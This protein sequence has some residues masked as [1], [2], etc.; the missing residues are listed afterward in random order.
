MTKAFIS[1]FFFVSNEIS[2]QLE[3]KTKSSDGGYGKNNI[4]ETN[5]IYSNTTTP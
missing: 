5:S 1:V 3:Y 2:V 4:S